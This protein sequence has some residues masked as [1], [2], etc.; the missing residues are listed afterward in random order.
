MIASETTV[1]PGRSAGR[2]GLIV[3]GAIAGALALALLAGGGGLVWA[4]EPRRT[5]AA[6]TPPARS[7]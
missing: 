4:Q 5:A 1:R 6:T 2:I 7:T 3:T